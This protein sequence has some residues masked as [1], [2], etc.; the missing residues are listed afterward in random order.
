MLA[1][2]TVSRCG[3]CGEL[4]PIAGAPVG[5]EHCPSQRA[6]IHAC[7]QCAHFDTSQRFQCTQLVPERIEDKAAPNDLCAWFTPAGE[8]PEEHVL[9]REERGTTSAARSTTSSRSQRA[10]PAG[11]RLRHRRG[12][13]G[14]RSRTECSP[15]DFRSSM[16]TSMPKWTFFGICVQ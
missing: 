7:R 13:E 16:P 5:S 15:P 14:T 11:R 8:P 2:R 6:A 9:Q 10:H 4:L 1:Q 3:A 12:P